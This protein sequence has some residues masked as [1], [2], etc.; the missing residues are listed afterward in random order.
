MR[1]EEL[2]LV[3]IWNSH[4][5][6]YFFTYL[7][8][9]YN[10]SQPDYLHNLISVQSTGRTRFSSVV[11]LAGSSVYLPHC[12]SPTAL[13][14]M[15]HLTCE[16]SSLLHSVNLILFTLLLVHFVM[17]ISPRHSHHLRSRHLSLPRPFTIDLKFISITNPFLHSHSINSSRTAFTDLN[18]CW[19]TGALALV[20][21]SFYFL[22]FVAGYVC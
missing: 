16:I 12:K 10:T 20:C 5:L 9:F 22:Y 19:I 8:S 18:L 2:R 13:S 1:E 17:R 3:I 21:F 14:H 15:H 6:K 11:T 4:N 7:Q